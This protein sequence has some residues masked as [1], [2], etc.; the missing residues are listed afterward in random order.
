MNED[1]EIF[2]SNLKKQIKFKFNTTN[3]QT[4]Y[5]YYVYIKSGL[6]SSHW[7]VNVI[8]LYD[9]QVAKHMPNTKQPETSRLCVAFL[10]ILKMYQSYKK[11]I[12]TST[13]STKIS[14]G[15]ANCPFTLVIVCVFQIK[16]F[17]TLFMLNK[18][19]FK[20]I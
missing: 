7:T 10:F 17:P 11:C 1:H 14:N 19:K 16:F 5:E 13:K 8:A 3:V 18:L 15:L 2:H 9:I 12:N 20:I 6:E 4:Y